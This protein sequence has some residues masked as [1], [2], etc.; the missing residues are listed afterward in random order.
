MAFTPDGRT[1]VTASHDSTVLVWDV[2]GLRTTGKWSGSAAELW[3]LLADPSPERAGQANW[4]M[5]DRPAESLVVLRQ[6]LKPVAAS[7]Q[8]V[9]QLVADLDDKKFAVREKAMQALTLLGPAAEDALTDRLA[10]RAFAGNKPGASANFY[11]P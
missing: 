6:H 7:K 9:Q 1:L 8:T 11:W 5:V 2:T 4:S 3:S 10:N